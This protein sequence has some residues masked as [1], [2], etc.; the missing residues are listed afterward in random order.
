ME[1]AGKYKERYNAVVAGKTDEVLIRNLK[2]L[3]D[4]GHGRW[5]SHT[6]PLHRCYMRMCR[7]EARRRGLKIPKFNPYV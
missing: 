4:Q 7:E 6:S 3:D 5:Y 2:D 1:C